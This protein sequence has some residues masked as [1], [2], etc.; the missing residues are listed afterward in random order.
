MGSCV[1]HN[2]KPSF[3]KRRCKFLR[4]FVVVLEDTEL[5]DTIVSDTGTAV[6]ILL[7]VLLH[8]HGDSPWPHSHNKHKHNCTHTQKHTHST[9]PHMQCRSYST[10]GHSVELILN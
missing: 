2:S 3:R 9:H 4:G 7:E 5:L 10:A 8:H 6:I 1:E